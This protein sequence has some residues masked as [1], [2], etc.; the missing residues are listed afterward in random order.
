MAN[1]RYFL[2]YK[3]MEKEVSREEWIKAER[4]AG[5]RSKFGDDKEATGGFGSS[6]GV[7]GRVEYVKE[8][9]NENRNG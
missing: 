9:S 3:G 2:S 4:D 8:D 7:S 5:F 6:N 1:K